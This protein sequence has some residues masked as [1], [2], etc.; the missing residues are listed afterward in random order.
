MKIKLTTR[1]NW[2]LFLRPHSVNRSK[3]QFERKTFL[4]YL[5]TFK[6]QKSQKKHRAT[7]LTSV[8]ILLQH[9]V[10]VEASGSRWRSEAAWC[11]QILWHFGIYFISPGP[12]YCC[13]WRIV[14]TA[15][16]LHNSAPDKWQCSHLALNY[17][18]DHQELSWNWQLFESPNFIIVSFSHRISFGQLNFRMRSSRHRHQSHGT[19]NVK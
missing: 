15:G 5:K 14:R 6:T 3:G 9:S 1:N 7:W 12:E 11:G 4:N 19:G 16:Y 13:R 18:C 8:M 17:A 2:F 10:C